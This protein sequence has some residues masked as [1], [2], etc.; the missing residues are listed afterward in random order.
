MFVKGK[1]AE[2][3]GGARGGRRNEAKSFYTLE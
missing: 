1:G 3:G 2:L